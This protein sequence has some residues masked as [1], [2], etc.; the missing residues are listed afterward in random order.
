MNA[1]LSLLFALL[2]FESLEDQ[3]SVLKFGNVPVYSS[4][5]GAICHNA[6]K[7]PSL[8]SPFKYTG[9]TPIL[10]QNAPHIVPPVA[11]LGA[12]SPVFEWF[13]VPE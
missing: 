9:E 8:D 7:L 1:L 3:S 12:T 6:P 5:N 2:S 10:V 11:Q 4:C 13:I